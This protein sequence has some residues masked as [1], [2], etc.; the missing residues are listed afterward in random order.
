MS[1][2]PN[3]I[4]ELQACNTR[5]VLE[6]RALRAENHVRLVACEDS[7]RA[8]VMAFFGIAGQEIGGAPHVPSAEVVRL[9]ARLIVEECF[10]LLESLFDRHSPHNQFL[11]AWARVVETINDAPVRVD[12]PAFADAVID[13]L[14]VLE[15]ALVAFGIDGEPLWRAVHACNMRKVGGPVVDGKL[16]K[17]SGW[18]APDIAQLLRDQGWAP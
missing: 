17:P 3:T 12:L 9:R 15:G 2:Q 16:Q 14:Y 4:T 5:L 10:E 7:R 6:N 13:S 18:C 1:T 8:D 11:H